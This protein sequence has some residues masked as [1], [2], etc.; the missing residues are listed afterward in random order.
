[1]KLSAYYKQKHWAKVTLMRLFIPYYPDRNKE[2][3]EINTAD[4]DAVFVSCV[5]DGSVGYIRAKNAIFGGPGVL[6]LTYLSKEIDDCEPDYSLYP[7]DFVKDTSYGFIS[8]G[9]IRKCGFCK[10]HVIEGDIVQV[11]T[12]DKIVRHSKVKFMDNNVLALPNHKEI[13]KELID[14]H[15]KCQFNQGLD[16]RLVDEFNSKLLSKLNYFGEYVFAFDDVKSKKTISDKLEILNW[17]KPWQF[18]FFVYI[19]PEMPLKDTI[20]R[21]MWLKEQECLPYIMRDISCWES[22]FNRFYVDIS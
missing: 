2:F 22:E 9:C 12:V 8:R 19:H 7:K 21:I 1:M 18:K 16:I 6:P 3:H 15:M 11:S 14:K 5:F 20:D 10:V 4:F 13:L 17:R